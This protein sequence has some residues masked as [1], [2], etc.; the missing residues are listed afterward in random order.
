MPDLYTA[1]VHVSGGRNGHAR[2][3]DGL[4]DL[5]LALPGALGGRGGASNPEQ[6]FAAGFA[7]CFT[8]SLEHAARQAR[9]NPGTVTVDAAVTLTN[10]ED[11]T[12]GLKVTLTPGLP[13]LDAAQRA[14][15]IAEAER[16]CAYSNATR[17]LVGLTI[18]G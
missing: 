7:A 12:Y 9:L 14:A 16:I 6:L 17:G 3:D 4:L 1:H 5:P 13:G 2:A 15:V 11:G 18:M 8:S 10:A